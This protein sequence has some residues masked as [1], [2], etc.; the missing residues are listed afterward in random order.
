VDSN[1]AWNNRLGAVSGSATNTLQADPKFVDDEYRVAS[2][3]PAINAARADSS[4]S[5]DRDRKPRPQSGGP[6]LGP[7]EK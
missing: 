2:G 4:F 7:Y 1:L 5:P 6:D 3:S